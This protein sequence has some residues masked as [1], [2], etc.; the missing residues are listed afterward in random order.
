LLIVASLLL[1]TYLLIL[2]IARAPG[3]FFESR[4]ISPVV[5]DRAVPLSYYA[6][7]PLAL[8]PFL[9][10]LTAFALWRAGLTVPIQPIRQPWLFIVHAGW[11]VP[12][13]LLAWCAAIWLIMLHRVARASALRMGLVAVAMPIVWL[14]LTAIALAMPLGLLLLAAIWFSWN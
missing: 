4:T 9:S 3:Y 11:I 2:S 13:L 1:M 12:M 14:T 7:A 8:F 10:P 6:S 5:R